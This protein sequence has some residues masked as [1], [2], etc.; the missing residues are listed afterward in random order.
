MGGMGMRVGYAAIVA[1]TLAASAVHGE[2]VQIGQIALG[3]TYYNRAGATL[4][5]HNADLG[6]CARMTAGPSAAAPG[7]SIAT[8]LL[9]DG[10]IAGLAAV[11]V[12]NCMLVRGWRVVRLP[13][14]QGDEV[15]RLSPEVLAS[16]MAPWIGEPTPPGDIVRVWANEAAHPRQITLA[17]RPAA[18]GKE[19]LSL[20]L[21]D[22]APAHQ[23]DPP[24]P[25]VT[26]AD[27]TLDPRWSMKP[28]KGAEIAAPASGAGVILVRVKGISNHYGIGMVLA[29]AGPTPE[30]PP[31]KVDH[32]TNAL[33]AGVGWAFAKA[34]GNWF[35]FVAPPGRWRIGG[36]GFLNLCLGAPSFELR[37]GDVIYAGTF[38]LAGED[39]G[40]DLALGP[41][42]D[43][44]RGPAR[45]RL[46][47][48]VYQNG[49]RG[50]CRGI[51]VPYALE[52]P[53]APFEPGYDWGSRA[54]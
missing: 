37:E 50:D 54:P 49:A 22:S 18:P 10:P 44:L 48:A 29:R 32:A 3:A 14:S 16:R 20:R 31:S 30:T 39:F 34:D 11:R 23:S 13:Q 52:I 12:E 21:Y 53:D 26:P 27:V 38:D 19:Q 8:H 6:D 46:K 35:A 42:S 40:P 9:W 4:A 45:E 5:Q 24:L 15:Q 2:P 25:V 41:A 51:S 36:Y 43:Y 33:F 1:L 7:A 17:S 28:L 47:P